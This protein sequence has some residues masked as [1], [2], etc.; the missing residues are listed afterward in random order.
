MTTIHSSRLPSTI[1]LLIISTPSSI[2]PPAHQLLQLNRCNTSQPL[3]KLH[4]IDLASTL[5][6]GSLASPLLNSNRVNL[7][8][9]TLSTR[10]IQFFHLHHNPS[11]ISF[12]DTVDTFDSLLFIEPISLRCIISFPSFPLVSQRLH[13]T[14]P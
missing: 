12:C 9:L 14:R 7:F 13:G 8:L 5:D 3:H 2:V 6:H 4:S 11:C 10:H 1:N